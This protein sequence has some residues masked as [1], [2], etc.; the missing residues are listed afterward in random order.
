MLWCIAARW[1]RVAGRGR[2]GSLLVGLLLCPGAAW[3]GPTSLTVDKG[4]TA[5]ML[6]STLLVLL[7]IV[8]G[9]ALFYGGLVRA[10][11][12]LSIFSQVIGITALSILVWVGWGY[13]L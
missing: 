13:S 12:L 6:L 11:N 2:V 9:L 8:P 1:M 5:W 4:D 3:A 10:K 7:M